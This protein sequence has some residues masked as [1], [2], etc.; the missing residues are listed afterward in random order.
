MTEREILQKLTAICSSAEHCTYEMQEKM[1]RWGVDEAMQAKVIAYLVSEKYVDDE[2]YCRMFVREKIRFNKWGRRK[3]EQALFMKRIPK[4]I[5]R[6]VLDEV[7]DEEY[8]KVLRPLL[9]TKEK[10]IKANNEY[11]KNM[12]LA[13]FALSR[14][15]SFDLIRQ[16]L[17]GDVDDIDDSDE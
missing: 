17:S 9:K 12:K 14:G 3:V 1:R 7:P 4:E 8:L 10:S 16:C 15:F 2:R 13:K 6:T 5:S 11:E